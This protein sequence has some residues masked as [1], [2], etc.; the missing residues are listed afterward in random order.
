[1]PLCDCTYGFTDCLPGAFCIFDFASG[2][3]SDV[4]ADVDDD[5]SV[6]GK[7]FLHFVIA[8]LCFKRVDSPCK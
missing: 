5:V 7:A 6:E 3:A 8:H 2:D 1:M 4:P